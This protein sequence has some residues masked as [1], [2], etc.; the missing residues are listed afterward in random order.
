MAD[1]PATFSALI[2][3]TKRVYGP[4]IEEQVNKS[5]FLY[6]L[7]D[8]DTQADFMGE[9][10]FFPVTDEGGQSIG[11][12]GDNEELADSQA[13]SYNLAKIDTK[14][15][16]AVIQVTGK[17]IAA[18][19]KN[20]QAFLK[21]KQGE[22]EAKTKSLISDL[23]RQCYGDSYG[24]LGAVASDAANTITFGG[25][26]NMLWFRKNMKID[27]FD[28]T[29]TTKRNGAA[30]TKKEGRSITAINYA[31]RT[32]TYSGG[33]LSGSII[34]TDVVFR[35]DERLNLAGTVEGKELNGFRFMGDDGTDSLA[36]FQNVS[37]TSVAVWKANRLFNA[38]TLR[39]LT[40]DLLQQ[41]V[42]AV[43]T[44]STEEPT[45]LLMGLGQ[46]R[47]YLNTLRYDVRYEP[48][49]LKGGFKT[50]QYNNMDVLVD[51]DMLPQQVV[52]FVRNK[53]KKYELQ[54]LGILDHAGVGA[55]RIGH[56]DTYEMLIG[57]YGNLGSTRPNAIGRL[58]DLTEP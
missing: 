41:L 18:T 9:G 4:R 28:A 49:Q 37:R 47:M 38:G 8:E 12:Y 14:Q 3:T 25:D 48:Q 5:A 13:E 53:I 19:R 10:W 58:G 31:T 44:S 46:R 27:I 15:A 40:L 57:M 2:N 36:T 54:P 43:T 56:F 29:R 11:N 55:E 35:E 50:L 22:I 32:I 16:Y 6:K 17:A 34:A 23:N 33:D 39:P 1:S 42:D 30:G 7:F 21:A 26:V 20:M 51:K 45:H 52:C 24:T